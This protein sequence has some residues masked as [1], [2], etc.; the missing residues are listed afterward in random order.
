[1]VLAPRVRQYYEENP[2]M[3]SSPFGGVNGIDHV[4][5]RTVW[6]TLGI[7]VAGQQ[8][9]DIGCGR[10]YTGELV[11]SLGGRYGGADFVVSRTGFSLVQADAAQLPFRDGVAGLLTC[12][13][14]FEHFPDAAAA[15]HEFYRILAPGGSVF[16][17]VPNYA[18]I[19]GIVKWV[20]E[21]YGHYAPDTWA[22]FGRWQPQELEHALTP[23]K[24]RR[25]FAEAGFGA[26]QHTGYGHEVGLGLF[27]WMEHPAMPDAIRFR[28][29]RMFRVAGPAIVPWW[30][31]ASLHLF[32]RIEKTGDS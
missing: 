10:G 7:S 2:L 14:A 30:P 22:P 28:L 8:V 1:M 11:E 27:P 19:A 32:W 31:A 29:Q 16:L 20:C 17:S 5:L 13:D 12:I 9:L 15:V 24:I 25:L 3:V 6:E 18:N 23:G 4:L 26:M 21:H